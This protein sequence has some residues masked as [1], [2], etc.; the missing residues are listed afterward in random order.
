[1]VI[2]SVADGFV[3]V[4][5]MRLSEHSM[6][7]TA[8]IHTITVGGAAWRTFSDVAAFGRCVHL[9]ASAQSLVPMVVPPNGPVT[10]IS[11]RWTEPSRGAPHRER[12][13][14]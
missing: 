2:V 13:S 9:S 14:P 5:V 8:A 6:P 12:T 7:V 10:N 11:S 4:N 1:M 3:Q